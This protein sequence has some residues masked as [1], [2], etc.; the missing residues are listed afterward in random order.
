MQSL[1]DAMIAMYI[2]NV[3]QKMQRPLLQDL[4]I[5]TPDHFL[6]FTFFTVLQLPYI[7]LWLLSYT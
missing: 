2:G 3:K 7:F 5:F 6:I 4:C 1:N